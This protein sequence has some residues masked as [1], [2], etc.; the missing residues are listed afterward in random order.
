MPVLCLD[1]VAIIH[2]TSYLLINY[3]R[4]CNQIRSCYIIGYFPDTVISGVGDLF[5]YEFVIK[6]DHVE[7]AYFPDSVMPGVGDLFLK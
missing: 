7:L 1:V 4:I 6:S 3:Q 2:C 5:Q